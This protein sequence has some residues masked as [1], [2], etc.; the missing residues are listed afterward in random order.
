MKAVAYD[1]PGRVRTVD[2]DAPRLIE[3]T[4]AL[5]RVTLAG[6][7]GTDL[8]LIGGHL[9]GVTS[10][11]VLG[12]EF[13]GD[14][15]EVGVAVS[16]VRVGDR[17]LASDYTACG[18]CRWCDRGEHWQ[19]AERQFFGSGV[20]F[21][22]ALAGAQAEYVRV[23]LAD[24]TLCAIP[25]GVSDEAAILLCDNLPTGW[26]AVDLGGLAAG[27]TVAIV[28]GGPIGQL[29]A[30]CAQVRG[31]AAV[32]VI[33]PNPLRR[34][35]ASERGSLGVEP[36]MSEKLVRDM[37]DGDGA[38]LVVEAGGIDATL[39]ATFGLCRKRGRIVSVGVHAQESW[40][41]PLARSFADELLLRFAIGDSIR[42]RRKLL[43]L[44]ASGMLP[45]ADVVQARVPIGEA[46]LGYERMVRGDVLKVVVD[47]Q[48]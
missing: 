19:C 27:E 25:R 40:A 10:G 35:F 1:A 16:G 7:C 32:V 31:A 15:V 33:E 28:G 36:A 30:L 24:V 18:R 3:P 17:V 34:A 22:P 37:T 26:A 43:Q 9:P 48:A 2:V 14:V 20:A 11:L 8:H 13:V 12:H 21:G 39:R 29:A 23:P 38:D 5:V 4:D 6:I 47:M 41:F 46:A 44:I 42:D 45:A